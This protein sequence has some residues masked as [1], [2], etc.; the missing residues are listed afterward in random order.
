M[1]GTPGQPLDSVITAVGMAE[2]IEVMVLAVMIAIGIMMLFATPIADFV[3]EH[4]TV[5]MLAHCLQ[6][7]LLHSR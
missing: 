7:A 1:V 4:P 5:K 2:H 6:L 3:Q